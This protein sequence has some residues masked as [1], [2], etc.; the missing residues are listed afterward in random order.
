MTVRPAPIE[1]MRTA[2]ASVRRLCRRKPSMRFC[3]AHLNDLGHWSGQS[4]FLKASNCAVGV[5]D[6]RTMP[7][8]L[9]AQWIE[10]W[11]S[12]FFRCLSPGPRI[13]EQH[14]KTSVSGSRRSSRAMSIY[15]GLCALRGVI[16]PGIFG[17]ALARV[18]SRSRTHD[19]HRELR[20]RHRFAAGDR[21]ALPARMRSTASLQSGSRRP[22][23]H[24]SKP[25][26]RTCEQT[27]RLA[28]R[29]PN[30]GLSGRMR[31]VETTEHETTPGRLA[32][33]RND[34][35]RSTDTYPCRIATSLQLR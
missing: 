14:G 22:G 7:P 29:I 2:G 13:A 32:L 3:A 11:S 19:D 15:V 26:T 20:L 10:H 28:T 18:R 6:F 33:P 23:A 21:S 25:F 27:Q 17:P 8:A 1:P 34:C 9:V 31:S 12:E 16:A 5:R 35:G 24:R 30:A 4:G